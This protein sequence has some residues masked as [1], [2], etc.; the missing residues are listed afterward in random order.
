MSGV[1]LTALWSAQIAASGFVAL[2][3]AIL[4]TTVGLAMAQQAVSARRPRRTDQPPVS[5]IVPVKALDEGFTQAQ[6]SL[7]RQT[8]PHFDVTITAK[9]TRSPALDVARAVLAAHPERES[10][11]VRSQ[12]TF[13]ASP[14]VNNLHQAVEDAPHD[15]IFM[16]D[17]NIVVPDDAMAEAVACLTGRVGLVVAAPAARD[18]R[19]FA[20]A[21]EASIMNQSHG[22]ILLAAATLGFGFGVGK[23]MVFRRSDLHKAGGFESI[24]HSVGEDSA[25][26]RK[27]EEVD[28]TTVF[29]GPPI[30]QH[31]GERRLTDVFHRQL[32]WTVI[33]RHNEKAAF[34]AEPLGLAS[35]AALAA[36]LAGPLW[37]LH[38]L[39]AAAATLAL[40]FA[41]ETLLALARGWDVSTTAPL[42]MT[43][44]DTMML[45]VWLRAWFTRKV[46]WAAQVMDAHRPVQTTPEPQAARGKD[47]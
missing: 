3:L 8:Y 4:A 22:R 5:V 38:P 32:R 41:L 30:Y 31:L 13:A 43:A 34:L 26:A 10:R 6:E 47:T 46:V 16:K 33:R 44:R 15:I 19:N 42:A 7:F 20:A 24:A 17:S 11:I 40:W 14:K 37:G 23:L 21:I 18:A 27:L 9:E 28:R 1:A 2:S 12:A 35:C 29:M 36:A 45:I 39:A 25:L